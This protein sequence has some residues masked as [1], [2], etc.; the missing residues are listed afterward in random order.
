MGRSLKLNELWGM[1]NNVRLGVFDKKTV[2]GAS[3]GHCITMGT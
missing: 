3:N 2:S 1:D